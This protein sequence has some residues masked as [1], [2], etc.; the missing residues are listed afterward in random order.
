MAKRN[1]AKRKVAMPAFN[2]GQTFCGRLVVVDQKRNA[3][4]VDGDA[5][6][7]QPARFLMPYKPPKKPRK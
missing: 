5:G 1:V 6:T 3:F 4:W 7:V 2:P